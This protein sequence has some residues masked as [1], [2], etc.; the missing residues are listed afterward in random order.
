[1]AR[2]VKSYGQEEG[3]DRLVPLFPP[4]YL[5]I[6]ENVLQIRLSNGHAPEWS[7]HERPLMYRRV[8]MHRSNFNFVRF[9]YHIRCLWHVFISCGHAF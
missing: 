8:L 9:I 3:Y 5:L 2:R 1:M 4:V 6:K 7:F